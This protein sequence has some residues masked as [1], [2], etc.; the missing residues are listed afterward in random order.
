MCGAVLAL[1]GLQALDLR[2]HDDLDE[3][4]VQQL[5]SITGL[6]SLRLADCRGMT[7]HGLKSIGSLIRL[8]FLELTYSQFQTAWLDIFTAGAC[9]GMCINRTSAAS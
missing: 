9:L 4:G 2:G 6:S 3:A 5:C 8:R 7:N 1:T